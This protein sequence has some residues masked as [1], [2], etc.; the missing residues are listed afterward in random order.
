MTRHDYETIAEA[1]SMEMV[2]LSTVKQADWW[3]DMVFT[4]AIKLEKD[5]K[6]FDKELFYKNCGL[7]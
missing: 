6:A 5:N 1:F 2:Q 4:M 3:R 7:K